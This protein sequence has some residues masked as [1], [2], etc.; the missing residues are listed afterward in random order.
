LVNLVHF[1]A[2]NTLLHA[3]KYEVA[4]TLMTLT[5]NSAAVKCG[6]FIAYGSIWSSLTYPSVQL[7]HLVSPAKGSDNNVKLIILDHLDTLQS[8]HGHILNSLI[9]DILQVLSR[10]VFVL[11]CLPFAD[12]YHV[13]QKAMS[14]VFSSQY[15]EQVSIFL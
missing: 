6:F 10:S 5:Q 1:Q 13:L 2:L 14:I 9:M 3:I 7:P 15:V 12:N 8:T 11:F 4:T